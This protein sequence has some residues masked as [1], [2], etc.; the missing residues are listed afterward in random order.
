[1]ATNYIYDWEDNWENTEIPDLIVNLKETI[2]N[3]ERELKLLEERKRM[4]EADLVLTEEL[5]EEEK[6][7]KITNANLALTE[8]I[9][10]VKAKK[11]SQNNY[12]LNKRRDAKN[13]KK[14]RNS[15]HKNRKKKRSK[16]RD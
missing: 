16:I 4:E 3:R 2:K 8:P 6:R 15:N 11:K 1:M 7:N 5:F 12:K 14:N 13:Y 10:F 9:K